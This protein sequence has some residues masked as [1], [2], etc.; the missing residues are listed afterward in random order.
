M[1]QYNRNAVEQFI[2]TYASELVKYKKFSKLS[3]PTTPEIL[4]QYVDLMKLTTSDIDVLVKL[5]GYVTIHSDEIFTHAE[6]LCDRGKPKP[7][8]GI[9]SFDNF[10]EMKPNMYIGTMC[11]TSS[12]T[13][14]SAIDKDAMLN[15]EQR[16]SLNKMNSIWYKRNL[17]SKYNISTNSTFLGHYYDCMGRIFIYRNP[18]A[19]NMLTLGMQNLYGRKI[20]S[21][22]ISKMI[23]GNDYDFELSPQHSMINGNPQICSQCN[24]DCTMGYWNVNHSL[25]EKIV[26][27]FLELMCEE[28]AGKPNAI[29]GMILNDV[30]HDALEIVNNSP[31][32]ISGTEFR[33]F[34]PEKYLQMEAILYMGKIYRNI[35]LYKNR[36]STDFTKFNITKNFAIPQN[37][38][39][40]DMIN[41]AITSY[42]LSRLNDLTNGKR[43]HEYSFYDEANPLTTINTI[44]KYKIV[45]TN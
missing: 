44:K 6:S 19:L 10:I 21:Y 29:H 41:S 43:A 1:S 37:Q 33:I 13:P 28:N 36:I 14:K 9:I 31:L 8:I 11:T 34:A 40:L 38:N 4:Q 35:K 17:G 26:N 2:T 15:D 32:Y 18:K 7:N 22:V 24:G 12:W 5:F 45:Q 42:E 39:S 30:S 3:Q 16:T 23:L 27:Y 25:H 20:F